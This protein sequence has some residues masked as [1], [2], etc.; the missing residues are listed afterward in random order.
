MLQPLKLRN[1]G[2]MLLM[3]VG[4]GTLIFAKKPGAL[5]TPSRLKCAAQI[6]HTAGYTDY[7]D[8][9]R[10]FGASVADM[11]PMADM[12]VGGGVCVWCSVSS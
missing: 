3:G 9:A 1:N 4:L 11:Q 2:V 7:P 5:V 6:V 12:R 10:F 8:A